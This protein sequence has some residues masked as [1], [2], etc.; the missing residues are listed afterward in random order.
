[1]FITYWDFLNGE[2]RAIIHKH[3]QPKHIAVMHIPPADA[4]N[5]TKEIQKLDK[6]YPNVTIFRKNMANRVYK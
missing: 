6:E 3:I 4:E 1:L 5:V 2:A